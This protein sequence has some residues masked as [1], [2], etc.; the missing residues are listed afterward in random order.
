MSDTKALTRLP[1]APPIITAIAN[2]ITPYFLRKA[3]NSAVKP[4]G[5]AGAGGAGLGSSASLIFLSSSR[6]LSILFPI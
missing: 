6:I 2:P 5:G 3:I 1:A 4:A